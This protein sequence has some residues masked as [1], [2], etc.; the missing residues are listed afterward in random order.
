[1]TWTRKRMVWLAR[2]QLSAPVR[3]KHSQR[4]GAPS[5]RKWRLQL[6]AQPRE[7]WHW[8]TICCRNLLEPCGFGERYRKWERDRGYF[9]WKARQFFILV[10]TVLCLWE[11]KGL[12]TG[13]AVAQAETALRENSRT[14][15][16]ATREPTTAS[17]PVRNQN[18]RVPLSPFL[19]LP[20]CLGVFCMEVFLLLPSLFELR[21]ESKE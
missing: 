11:C 20:W 14:T 4:W 16:E 13:P 6:R 17:S 15:R 9:I 12:L 2:N 18:W 7:N 3:S 21:R 5:W 1:M 19:A 8:T 10:L